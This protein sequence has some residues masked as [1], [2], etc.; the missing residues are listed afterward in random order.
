[1]AG[2]ELIFAQGDGLVVWL[3]VAVDGLVV[4]LFGWVSFCAGLRWILF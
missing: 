1:M 2:F 4:W 3:F